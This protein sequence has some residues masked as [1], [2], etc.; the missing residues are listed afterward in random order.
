MKSTA[1]RPVQQARVTRAGLEGDREWMVVDAPGKLVSAREL[2]ALFGV[3]SDVPFTGADV[4]LRLRYDGC[5]DL[6]VQ[7]PESGSLPVTLFG[8]TTLEARPAG[9]VADRWLRN[10]LGR[11]ELSRWCGA[12]TR[13][14]VSWIRNT[15]DPATTQRSWTPAR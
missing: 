10:A 9:P 6:D 2:P 15:A 11:E 12:P 1:I 3:T 13:P 8:K 5:P 4:D 14:G 7:R